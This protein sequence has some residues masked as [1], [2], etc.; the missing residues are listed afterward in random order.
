FLNLY[1]PQSV[2]PFMARELGIGATIASTIVTA[3][4]LAVALTAPFAG[5][6]SDRFGRRRMIIAAMTA[7]LVPT[8]MLALA[9][10]LQELVFWRFVQGLLLPPI[11]AVTVA[12]IGH[13]WPPG[14]ATTVVGIYSAA[15]AAGGFLGRFIPGALADSLT[16]R[17]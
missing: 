10:S 6:L 15:S 8:I 4:T 7:V 14:E 5:A 9:G 11:F 13:E 3:G 12:Y 16:W 2:L 1:S 17:G